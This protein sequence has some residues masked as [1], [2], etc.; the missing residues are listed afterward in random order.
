[1]AKFRQITPERGH[2]IARFLRNEGAFSDSCS[3]KGSTFMKLIHASFIVVLA[4]LCSQSRAEPLATVSRITAVTVYADRA[5]ITRQTSINVT[6]TGLLELTF[7]EL[8]ASLLD[9]S[10]QV[11]GEGAAKSTL[12]DVT[13]RPV[14]VDFAAN[15]RVRAIEDELR[16]LNRKDRSLNDRISVLGQQREYVIKIQNATTTPTKDSAGAMGTSDTWLKLLAFS[17]EQLSKINTEQQGL[18][19]Q[20]EDMQAR[21]RALE[22]QLNELRGTGT[23]S[24]K[25]VAVRLTAATTGPLNLTLRYAVP[26]ARW[27]PSYDARVLSEENTVQLGYFGL[28]RQNTGEDWPGINLTLSTARPSLGGAAPEL[29]PWVVQQEQPMPLAAAPMELRMQKARAEQDRA[30][31]SAY[32]MAAPQAESVQATYDEAQIETQ[33]TS[34]SFVIQTP[35]TIPSDNSP[36][37]VP[38]TTARLTAA[39]EYTSTPKQ[40]PAAFLTAKV[41]NTSEFP[42]LAGSMNVFLDDTFIASSNLRGVMPGE[43]FDLALGA[44]EGISVKRKLNNRFTED[45]GLVSKSKRITYDITLSV[46]NNKKTAGTLVLIDQIPVSRHEKIVVKVLAP[47]ERESKPDADGILKWTLSLKP[48]EKR[49]VPLKFSVE[50]PADLPVSGLE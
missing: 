38:V 43:T 24:F 13:P 34:A 47:S 29:K 19:V 45:T 32:T 12:L 11:S 26:G 37:K 27:T 23:R 31:S 1:M 40:I 5:V 9:E 15:E 36:Q 7:D 25:T 20:R 2:H 42:L 44:D 3:L 50:Y 8:P 16:D 6:T 18:D 17:E 14:F 46:Q 22:Q 21:R 39:K 35:A 30:R 41:T 28:V 4:V 49:D 48:G 10:L 33:A